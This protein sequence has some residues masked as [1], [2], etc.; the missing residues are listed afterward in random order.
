TITVAQ[1]AK[2]M[3]GG[4]SEIINQERLFPFRFS[5]Q[6]EYGCVTFG[7]NDL[8]NLRQYVSE[9]RVHHDHKTTDDNL[10]CTDFRDLGL[11]HAW[12]DDD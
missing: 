9:Q 3:K 6:H 5:W 11:Q 8:Q 1:M 10:E 2:L 12:G 4:S 7:K